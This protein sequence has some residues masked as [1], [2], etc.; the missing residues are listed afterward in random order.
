MRA[1]FTLAWHSAWNRRAVLG[2][3][4]ASI[5]LA[6][7]ML[8]T[9]ERVR[10]DVRA[11]FS[12]SVSGT[13]LI[14]GPRTGAVQLLLYSVFRIGQAGNNISMASVEALARHPAVAWVVPLSIGDTH[15]GFPVVATVP[16]YFT[17]FHYGDQ[18]AL[19]LQAGQ[20]MQALFDTVVGAEVAERLHYTIGSPV[21]LAHG[22]G[23]IEGHDHG[24]HPFRVAG[25]LARTG[26]PVDRSVH[27]SLQAMEALHLD[28]MGGMRIPGMQGEAVALTPEHLR[29]RQVSAVLVGLKNRAAVFAVQRWVAAQRSEPLMAVMPAVTLDEL[30]SVVGVGE[31]VLLAVTALVSVVSL[32]GLVAVILAGL[33]ARRRE[34]AILRALGAGP[35]HVLGLLALEGAMLTVL[36]VA[37]GWLLHALLLWAAQ[38]WVQARLGLSLT[39]QGTQVSQWQWTGAVLAAGWVASLLPAWRAYQLSLQ[40]GLTPRL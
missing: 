11:S 13:D 39:F 4:L 23:D 3:T 34:L 19:R 12:Q 7:F 17:R 40:D 27:I 31:Q 1:L 25:I 28:W 26:T 6:T 10:I 2:L 21:V 15:H 16:D 18:Q 37:C 30:W 8:L 33:Q 24:D 32:M 38:D 9:I 14:V 29:P 5:A 35:W 20:P 36:G 22:E